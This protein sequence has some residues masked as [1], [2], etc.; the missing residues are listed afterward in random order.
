MAPRHPIWSAGSRRPSRPQRPTARTKNPT[1][2][3]TT[4][5]ATGSQCTSDRMTAIRPVC[6][7]FQ[8]LL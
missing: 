3:E 7:Q 8:L 4:I 2:N 6:K 5:V 1:T